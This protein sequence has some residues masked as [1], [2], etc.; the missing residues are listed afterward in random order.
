[1]DQGWLWC[2]CS[3]MLI[4]FSISQVRIYN[5]YYSYIISE[6]ATKTGQMM[7]TVRIIVLDIG[8][9]LGGECKLSKYHMLLGSVERKF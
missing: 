8:M 4:L 3:V 6:S 7:N 5:T 2:C 1:M 9:L